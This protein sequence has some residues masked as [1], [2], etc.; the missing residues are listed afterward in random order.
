MFSG[1]LGSLGSFTVVLK[2]TLLWGMAGVPPVLTGH[3][4]TIIN[5]VC[6]FHA[7][8]VNEN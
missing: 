8:C 4:V 6:C 7:L 5:R 2:I 3:K 1:S